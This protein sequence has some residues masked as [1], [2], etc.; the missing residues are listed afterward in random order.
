MPDPL[1]ACC[2]QLNLVA[3]REDAYR[4]RERELLIRLDH[5]APA[6]Q[7]IGEDNPP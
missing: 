4:P 1:H 6:K 2:V 7:C 3:L 5:G